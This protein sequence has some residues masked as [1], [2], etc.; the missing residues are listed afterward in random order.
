[1]VGGLL[2]HA[3]ASFARLSGYDPVFF[4]IGSSQIQNS[5]HIPESIGQILCREVGL[6]LRAFARMT[7]EGTFGTLS[8]RFKPEEASVLPVPW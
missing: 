4:K 5:P 7:I 3:W 1:M 8:Q 2:D 6:W